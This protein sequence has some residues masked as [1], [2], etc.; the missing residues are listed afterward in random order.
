[1]AR[2]KKQDLAAFQN[3]LTGTQFVQDNTA[4]VYATHIRQTLPYLEVLDA[5]EAV[6][7]GFLAMGQDCSPR[8][9]S[10]R[11]TAWS[12][13][14]EY[15]KTKGLTL[16]EPRKLT[17]LRGPSPLSHEVRGVLHWMVTGDR[18]KHRQVPHLTWGLLCDDISNMNTRDMRDPYRP[19]GFV[20]VEKAHIEI[21]RLWAPPISPDQ[22]LFPT[23]PGSLIPYPHRMFRRELRAYRD[24]IDWSPSGMS[25]D[26]GVSSSR[27]LEMEASKE[28]EAMRAGRQT[29]VEAME[30]TKASGAALQEMEPSPDVFE[31]IE[32][33]PTVPNI[34]ALL[35]LS[36]GG[37]EDSSAT[38]SPTETTLAEPSETTEQ[39]E[40][41]AG[42][43]GLSP[44]TPLGK[45][46]PL[47][48]AEDRAPCL[49]CTLP[50][51]VHA[52]AF[53][54]GTQTITNCAI[55]R[56]YPEDTCQMCEGSCPGV[57][58]YRA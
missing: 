23:K 33:P 21:L 18:F 51:E 46:A 32:E 29:A 4:S 54:R 43:A 47:G 40:C 17:V 9:L 39:R 52:E 24:S 37:E 3:F 25:S 13:F 6:T 2:K 48:T 8:K 36:P 16:A 7:A 38:P 57:H 58:S 27:E 34:E 31:V 20:L 35:A 1:M 28:M 19:N 26:R 49:T 45:E 56:G 15:A 10:A 41:L 5:V 55:V 11:R 50:Y 44:N 30:A 22:P 12:H 53:G 42:E 14:V